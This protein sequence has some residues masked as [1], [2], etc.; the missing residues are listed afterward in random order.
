MTYRPARLLG[1]VYFPI[2]R[3]PWRTIE[4]HNR[5]SPNTNPAR[6]RV[7][8]CP[9]SRYLSRLQ[10]KHNLL[11]DLWITNHHNT[12]RLKV[13]I[14]PI[15]QPH[16]VRH[17]FLFE[18]RLAR[19]QN[20]GL[21][22]CSKH[23]LHVL[24][25]IAESG[26]SCR[27]DNAHCPF[28]VRVEKGHE[29]SDA[30]SGSDEDDAAEDFGDA[31]DAQGGNASGP[32]ERWR[33][34]V[35]ELM[36]P[37]SVVGDDDGKG[38]FLVGVRDGGEFVIFDQRGAGEAD[39]HAGRDGLLGLH[40]YLDGVGG[41]F[42]HREI[43]LA[44]THPGVNEEE[45]DDEEHPE[46]R[47]LDE[48]GSHVAAAFRLQGIRC[49]DAAELNPD[50]DD[51]RPAQKSMRQFPLIV[52]FGAQGRIRR[53]A[54]RDQQAHNHA[55][56]SFHSIFKRLVH[57]NKVA[58]DQ[59]HEEQVPQHRTDAARR[60]HPSVAI[61]LGGVSTNADGPRA[62]QAQ[63]AVKQHIDAIFLPHQHRQENIRCYGCHRISIHEDCGFGCGCE[64]SCKRRDQDQVDSHHYREQS[65]IHGKVRIAQLIVSL[66][67]LGQWQGE[68]VRE[69][70]Q[71]FL[72]GHVLVKVV[73][74]GFFFVAVVVVV[75]LECR[76]A[77]LDLVFDH[78]KVALL[79]ER[80]CGG[81]GLW[82]L[83]V[84]AV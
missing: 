70:L 20:D 73:L 79:L 12:L 34:V 23:I 31:R 75:V 16:Q 64:Q 44:E 5:T 78:L 21:W 56:E 10:R 39:S 40:V 37:I 83:V 84:A 22:I 17:A 66:I 38:G 1:G 6:L 80:I 81:S 3:S 13:P 32:E 47:S 43:Y 27:P 71:I 69:S 68:V 61:Y 41:E 54:Q 55:G 30:R 65:L 19:V 77:A 8:N 29:R 52:K 76:R 4:N 53:S 67:V 72:V 62:W 60:V 46:S 82:C 26:R 58:K 63:H 15:R 9:I 18:R 42:L 45:A 14:C 11:G 33:R 35:D 28:G 7:K 51:Q 57:G 48:D 50:E 36:G 25:A 74:W 24:L 2:R 59:H 49:D